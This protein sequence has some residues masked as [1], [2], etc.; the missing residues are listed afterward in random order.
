MG[1]ALELIRSRRSFRSFDGRNLSDGE[2]EE[3]LNYAKSVETPY[4]LPIEWRILNAGQENLSVPVITGTDLYIA[5]KMKRAPHAEEAFGFGFE[6]VVLFAQSKGIGTTWIAGTMDRKAFERAVELEA[7]EVMPC[8]S[9]LGYPAKKMALKEIMMRKGVKA[10]SRL[11]FEELF[12]EGGF[13]TPI[14]AER[15]GELKDTL[16]M[17]RWAPS[18]VNR[19]PWRLVVCGD[20]VHFF[21]KHGKS[22]ISADGWD[23]QKID[24]GI[25]MC[26][27]VCGM[28]ERGCT[29]EFF[30]EDPGFDRPA[31][32]DYVASFRMTRVS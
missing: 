5:G 20:T 7:G 15:A 28:E 17:V 27:F 32:T 10:D 31:Y 11:A 19:Q 21:E 14:P 9:P 12:F 24:V 22:F 3:I 2:Q 26:H 8:I 30:L 25:A 18:A 16:E 6:R 29:P 1:K 13:D 23:L 4:Q